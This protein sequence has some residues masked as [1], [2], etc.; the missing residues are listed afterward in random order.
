VKTIY[1]ATVNL[2]QG[3][4]PKVLGYCHLSARGC[5]EK[6]EKIQQ[7]SIGGMKIC[8]PQLLRIGTGAHGFSHQ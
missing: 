4:T 8:E 7:L 1:G 3:A 6:G 2:G 5:Q